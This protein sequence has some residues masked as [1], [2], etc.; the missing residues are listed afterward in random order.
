MAQPAPAKGVAAPASITVSINGSPSPLNSPV[1]LPQQVAFTL[2]GTSSQ[3]WLYTWGTNKALANIF[4]GQT[5]DY[6]VLNLGPNPAQTLVV[7][8]GTVWFEAVPVNSPAPPP[9]TVEKGHRVE[10]G[11]KGTIMISSSTS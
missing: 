3:A 4:Q 6:L 5:N 10:T 7:G 8:P 1:T 9:P 11:V 2:T